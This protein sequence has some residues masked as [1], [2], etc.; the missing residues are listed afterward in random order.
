MWRWQ[1]S[2]ETMVQ[3][4]PIWQPCSLQVSKLLVSPWAISQPKFPELSPVQFLFLYKAGK[5][6]RCFPTAGKSL[7]KDSSSTTISSMGSSV[8]VLL[9]VTQLRYKLCSA[10]L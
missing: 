4:R 2:S 3:G 9:T 6:S 8:G 1:E 10:G 5:R 7:A